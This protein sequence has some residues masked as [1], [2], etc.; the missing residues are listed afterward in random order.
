ME[1]VTHKSSTLSTALSNLIKIKYL[2]IVNKTHRFTRSNA[3]EWKKLLE[4]DK[5]IIPSIS[6]AFQNF[7]HACDIC[8]SIG[9][10]NAKKL[11]QLSI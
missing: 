1:V 11:H 2:N 5:I 10:P 7:Y 9:S 8:E 4:D 3:D 6:T